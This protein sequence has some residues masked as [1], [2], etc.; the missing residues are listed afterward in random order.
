MVE[1]ESVISCIVEKDKMSTRL[2]LKPQVDPE[3]K[4]AIGEVKEELKK[5]GVEYGIE[6]GVIEGAVEFYNEYKDEEDVIVAK[7]SPPQHG[8]TG[9][10][11]YL[12]KRPQMDVKV[13]DD[14]SMNFR[15]VNTITRIVKGQPV[16]RITPPQ[17]GED[18]RDVFNHPV[19]AREY[20]KTRLPV[21]KNTEVHPQDPDMLVSSIDGCVVFKKNSIELTNYRI[22]RGNVD[23]S[24]GNIKFDGPVKIT[25]D[26]KAGFEVHSK[27]CI[28]INGTVEDATITTD[29]DVCVKGGFVGTGKGSICA[30]GDVRLRFVRNQTV[31]A[32]GSIV[33][34]KEALES[35]LYARRKIYV[36]GKGLGIAGGYAFA[37]EGMELSALGSE[38]EVKTEIQVGS[39]PKIKDTIDALMKEIED[40]STRSSLLQKQLTEIEMAK[41]KSKNLFE[42]LI[43]KMEKVMEAKMNLDMKTEELKKKKRTIEQEM[44]VCLQPII[45][46]QGEIFPGVYLSFHSFKRIINDKKHRKIFY[47]EKGDIRDTVTTGVNP[48]PANVK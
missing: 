36:A 29:G 4:L 13:N 5:A 41:K 25:G 11:E 27:S 26:V 10:T 23:Y 30:K 42:R 22:V 35:K 45:R 46:V 33:V 18:G 43:E 14:G 3:H 38:T 44:P 6:E 24:S 21:I 47:L 48:I 37:I 12:V 19:K 31:K 32:G 9:K 7:G 8:T 15:E 20:E 16:V 40:L 28:E 34:A 2:I 39:D 17:P 1:T